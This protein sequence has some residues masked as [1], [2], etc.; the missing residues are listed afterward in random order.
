M[1]TPIRDLL[2]VL[3]PIHF[4]QIHRATIV[5]LRAIAAI[6]RDDT[7]KG[8]IRLKNRPELLSVSQPFMPLFR[9][10]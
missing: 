3:D 8:L 10:M 2:Q 6:T 5:N 4:K 9:N 1:R 7:G